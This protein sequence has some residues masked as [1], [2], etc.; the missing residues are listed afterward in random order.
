VCPSTVSEPEQTAPDDAHAPWQEEEPDRGDE[1]GATP[2]HEQLEYVHGGAADKDGG[3]DA[4]R[5]GGVVELG[6]AEGRLAELA[7]LLLRVREPLHEAL[8]VDVFDAAAALAREEQRLLL[9]ALAAADAARIRLVVVGR[10]DRGGGHG[11]VLLAGQWCLHGPASRWR[12]CC[13]LVGIRGA[14][15]CLVDGVRTNWARVGIHDVGGLRACRKE[16]RNGRL[17]GGG[18]QML[19]GQPL[20]AIMSASEVGRTADA[21]FAGVRPVKLILV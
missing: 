1:D 11:V 7:V 18:R 5:H 17:Y 10:S 19:S 21:S 9:S 3:G 2:G 8:L 16:N 12:T 13:L 20:G 14:V 6:E 4:A 15:V